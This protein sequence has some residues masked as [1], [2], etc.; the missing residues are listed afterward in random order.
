MNHPLLPVLSRIASA[1]ERVS[2][3]EAQLELSPDRDAF[4]WQPRSNRLDPVETVSAVPL[5]LLV[6]IDAQRK[7][8]FDNTEQFAND[9]SANNVMLCGARGTGKSSL[10]KAVDAAVNR[11]LHPERH[12]L[13]IEIQRDDLSS[14]PTLLDRLRDHPRRFLLFCDDLSFEKEDA[15]Y[16]AL[17]SVLDGGIRGRPD[18]VL[19][20]ATSN[21]RHLM[22]REMIENEQSTAIS[23]NEAV[24][25]KISLS[26]RFGLWI[27]FH[28]VDQPNFL[29]MVDGYVAD[30]GIAIERDDL[31]R[32]AIA[33]AIGRGARSGRVAW[34][35]VEDLAGRGDRS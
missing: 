22:P 25:E 16:K 10:V 24:E 9:R 2:P 33:W 31:H 3:P 12:L 15:D 23:G 5:S 34:Q 29:R 35:F 20:Y 17:K 13:L 26:D 18:N 7:T 14:L 11:A 28:K 27:G 30:R 32:Q 6:G 19:F 1:L 21:R 8:V 4:V